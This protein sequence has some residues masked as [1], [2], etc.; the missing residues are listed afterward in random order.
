MRQIEEDIRHNKVTEEQGQRQLDLAEQEF[1]QR[2]VE[3]QQDYD[4]KMASLN[5]SSGGGN[6]DDRDSDFDYSGW[7]GGD[8]EG[9]FAG[10][11]QSEGQAA[12]EKELRDMTSKG[13]IPKEYVNLAAIGARGGSMGH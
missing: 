9:Y 1:E 11:R 8:W 2:K 4:Y 13:L 6:D 3:A 12:A 5:K 10:I 7:D